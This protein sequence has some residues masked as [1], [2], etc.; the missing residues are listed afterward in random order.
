M[1]PRRDGFAL[2][3]AI[4]AVLLMSAL[5][6]SVFFAADEETRAGA[7]ASRRVQAEGVAEEAV[8]NA[9][10]QL[11]AGSQQLPTVGA[12]NVVSD[13]DR[14]GTVVYITRLDST[15]F[16]IVAQVASTPIAAG[17]STR[18]GLVVSRSAGADGSIKID[19]LPDHAWSELF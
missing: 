4:L 11:R 16:S 1:T 15:L 12:T 17:A 6:A 8:V 18:I 5:V 10:M 3:A 9:A 7:A 2:I 13:A 14:A 19:L